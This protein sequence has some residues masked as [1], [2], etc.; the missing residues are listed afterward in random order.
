MT[1]QA[2]PT[3]P[4]RRVRTFLRATRLCGL[5]ALCTLALSACQMQST[6]PAT[7]LQVVNDKAL[8]FIADSNFDLANLPPEWWRSPSQRSDGFT[9]TRLG[10]AP[11]LRIETPTGLLLGRRFDAPMMERP[12]LRWSWY[13]DPSLFQGAGDGQ[14]RG[15]RLV[16]GFRG[17]ANR[18][19]LDRMLTIGHLDYPPYDRLMELSFGGLP[20]GSADNAQLELVASGGDNPHYVLR[21]PALG[22]AGAWQVEGIDIGAVYGLLWPTDRASDVQITFVAVGGV[23]SKLPE[24]RATLGYISEILL[25]R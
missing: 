25:A 18:D 7:P 4:Q 19:T 1:L 5:F 3:R 16:I 6:A 12:N 10:G 8:I 9:L 2:D 14:P 24:T 21:G 17:G 23:P 13:L 22:Q 15:I 20:A 11:V